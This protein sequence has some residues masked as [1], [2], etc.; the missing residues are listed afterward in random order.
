M[1]NPRCLGICL[2]YNA[3][4]IVE[5][6]VKHLLENNHELVVWDH[7]STD[8]TAE[9]LDRFNPYIRERHFLP[10]SFEFYK[11][12][13]HVSRHVIATYASEYDWISF[14]E[15]DEFLEG[16]DRQ[17]SYY[18]YV[19]D[20]VDSPY[21]WVQFNNMVFWYT[22]KDNPEEPSPRKRVR[23]YSIWANCGPRV[24]AWRARCMNVRW[25]NH[26]PAAGMKYPVNFNTC[27]YQ[28]RSE[29]QMTKRIHCRIGL[30]RG[31]LNFH[32]AFMELNQD[33]LRIP[34][35]RLHLDD[36]IHDLSKVQTFDWSEVY[37][38]LEA[39]QKQMQLR[40]AL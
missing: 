7:G 12:F 39:F 20:V 22:D 10:S 40:N 32:F 26:N 8:R 30:T 11:L 9:I 1:A 18:K 27:H 13:E 33:K 21:D 2:F 29:E 37:G 34:A 3:D 24:Y 4:D 23:H 25:F 28:A 17:D 5:D 16:P 14:P 15:S 19:C 6:A 38:T 36:G 35:D 31:A